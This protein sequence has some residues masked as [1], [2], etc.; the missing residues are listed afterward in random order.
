[1][2]DFY[3]FVA[4]GVLEIIDDVLKYSLSAS[5]ERLFQRDCSFE[6]TVPL[7]GLG[8]KQDGAGVVAQFHL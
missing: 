7:Y 1:M 6:R 2:D 5:E 8:R 3:L 4:V